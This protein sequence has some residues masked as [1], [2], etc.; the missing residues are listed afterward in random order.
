LTVKLKEFV[1]QG[2][3][4][5]HIN[6]SSYELLKTNGENPGLKISLMKNVLK[7]DKIRIHILEFESLFLSIHI[8][9]QV[10]SNG[11]PNINLRA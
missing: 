2:T 7:K 3:L 9:I 8:S 4:V 10:L 11:T 6:L 5:S 1:S